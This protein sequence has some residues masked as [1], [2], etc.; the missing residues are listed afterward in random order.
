MV[1]RVL[2]IP[3]AAVRDMK[4]TCDLYP[5]IVMFY[6]NAWVNRRPDVIVI[7]IPNRLLILGYVERVTYPARWAFEDVIEL[8]IAFK[9]SDDFGCVDNGGHG[10]TTPPS[11]LN[12]Q[13]NDT[14]VI[15]FD[16][17]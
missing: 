4:V 1:C 10:I 12:M 2:R 9:D 5:V 3:N 15:L 11:A 13:A 6:P 16:G 8:W 14:G 17:E 7:E